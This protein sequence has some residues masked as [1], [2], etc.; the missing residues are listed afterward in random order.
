MTT[1]NHPS[2]PCPRCGAPV[3]SDAD[4]CPH[5]GYD[6]ES[7]VRITGAPGHVH[8]FQEEDFTDPQPRKNRT[9]RTLLIV[10]AVVF[11]LA[12]VALGIYYYHTKS[13]REAEAEAALREMAEARRLDSIADLERQQHQRDS[14]RYAQEVKSHFVTFANFFTAGTGTIMNYTAEGEEET[15]VKLFVPNDNLGGS[16]QMQGYTLASTRPIK[17]EVEGGEMVSDLVKVYC[18]NCD[19]DQSTD[20]PRATNGPWNCIIVHPGECGPTITVYF[21]TASSRDT[22]LTGMV[23]KGMKKN[24]DTSYSGIKGYRYD[25]SL[26]AEDG[27]CSADLTVTKGLNNSITIN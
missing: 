12:D 20:S 10:L 15:K 9:A 7:T 4:T 17:Y 11:V 6:L 3:P 19:W 5:C 13:V 25:G 16:L 21:D 8:P 18:L 27:L 1:S 26:Y 24:S 2:Y 14:L 23:A 22:F